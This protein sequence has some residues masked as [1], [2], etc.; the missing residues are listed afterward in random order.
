M[1]GVGDEWRDNRGGMLY[2]ILRSNIGGSVRCLAYAATS[3]YNDFAEA[4]RT[5][6]T[7]KIWIGPD[8][9]STVTPPNHNWE[10][11]LQPVYCRLGDYTWD[12]ARQYPMMRLMNQ[13]GVRAMC[14]HIVKEAEAGNL[15]G[16]MNE[17]S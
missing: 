4:P 10:E 16:F 17:D 1:F 5:G 2:H 13:W 14:H 9:R 3:V 7:A 6:I 11:Q 8:W 12:L 15:N